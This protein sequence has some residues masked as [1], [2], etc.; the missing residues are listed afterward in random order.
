MLVQRRSLPSSRVAA[1]KASGREPARRSCTTGGAPAR[2]ARASAS[3]AS[4]EPSTGTTRSAVTG[5]VL[6]VPRVGRPVR[7]ALLQERIAALDRLVG[8][9]RQPRCLAGEQLLADQP[10]VDEVEGVLQH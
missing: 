7:L 1:A 10:V 6:V 2:S 4:E 5:S 9:V 3:T 8:H